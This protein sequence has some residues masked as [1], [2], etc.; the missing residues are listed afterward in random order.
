M[1]SLDKLSFKSLSSEEIDKIEAYRKSKHTAVLVILFSDIVNSTY[2]TENLGELSYSKLRHIHDELFNRIMCRDNAGVI[3]KQ[4]GDSFLCVFAEPSTAVL[5]AIEFQRAIHLNKKNLSAKDYTLTVRI[6]IHIGQVV[7]ENSLSRDI[8]GS[9][10]NRAARIESIANGGQILTSHAIWENASVWL[11]DNNENKIGWISYGRT[12]LKGVENKTEI[13]GFYPQ[14]TGPFATPMIFRKQRQT[15]K[16][17]WLGGLLLLVILSFFLVKNL[18]LSNSKNNTNISDSNPLRK[19][20]Y[21][22]FD[23]SKPSQLDTILFKDILLSDI[24]TSLYPD[25]IVTESDLIKSFSKQGK[26]YVKR[27]IITPIVEKYFADT[28]NFSGALLIKAIS[29]DTKKS[30]VTFSCSLSLWDR[31]FLSSNHY[32]LSSNLENLKSYFRNWLQDKILE[33][34][35]HDIQGLITE[36]NDSVIFFRLNNG[37]KLSRDAAIQVSREYS[38]KEGLNL[39]LN[40]HEIKMTY[41]KDKPQYADEIKKE[42]SDFNSHKDE[43]TEDLTNAKSTWV[44]KLNLTGKVIELYDSI[45]KATWINKGIFPFV[46]PRKG[47]LIYLDN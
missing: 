41:L 12:K 13:F 33:S 42:I 34:R 24:I 11:K 18:N 17:I 21:V 31:K 29:F 14:E 35:L 32:T 25:S 9:H 44:F 6:G 27:D 10:V 16:F 30:F 37:A 40:E 36:G 3:I 2:A 7:L 46:K 45:G 26:L 28:L 39:W 1:E 19:A 43:V 38:G 5:R 22:E 47:D 4:I 8:F 15:R 23:F 20:Y